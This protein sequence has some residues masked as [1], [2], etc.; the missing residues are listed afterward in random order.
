MVACEVMSV[1]CVVL[2]LAGRVFVAAGSWPASTLM[3]VEN[4]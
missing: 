2:A 4:N 1:G 3:S